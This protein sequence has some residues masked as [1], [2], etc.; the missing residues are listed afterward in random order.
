MLLRS[1]SRT[2]GRPRK[3]V[4]AEVVT[5][6][7]ER[8]SLNGSV[9]RVGVPPSNPTCVRSPERVCSPQM[10]GEHV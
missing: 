2:E 6:K 1:L 10:K 3:R 5:V 9:R 7:V 8:P 4:A